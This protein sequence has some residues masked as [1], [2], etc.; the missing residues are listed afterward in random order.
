MTRALLVVLACVSLGSLF[1]CTVAEGQI[2]DPSSD[3]NASGGADTK[4]GGTSPAEDSGTSGVTDD[5]T[6]TGAGEDTAPQDSGSSS[7][8][9][10]STTKDSGSS[11]GDTGSSSGDT[12]SATDTAPPPSGDPL[13]VDRT[14]C[15]DEINKYRATLS[16]PPYA[17]W[18]SASTCA[19]GQ[20]KSD[21][22]SGTA[23]GAFGKC[24]EFAQNECPGWPGPPDTMIKGCLKMM[25]DE[26]PGDFAAHGHYVNMSSTKYTQVA[27]G[28]HQTADGK[29]WSVQDFK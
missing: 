4:G 25:W 12:G 8:D 19:D 6:D 9:T 1:G 24:G 22:E 28:F 27:C 26:G 21:S 10:G 15:V 3:P 20:S 2:D 18:T 16:L 11:T 7:S 23:H 13:A 29:W 17:G 14:L 5:G